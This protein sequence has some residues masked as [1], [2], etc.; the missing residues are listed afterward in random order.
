MV[1]SHAHRTSPVLRGKW[2]LENIIGVARRAP[3]PDDVPALSDERAPETSRGRGARSWSSTAP[4]RR[5]RAAIACSTRWD[6]RSRT[7]TPSARGARGMAGRWASPIDASGQLVDGTRRR[8][9][10]RAAAGAGPATRDV[11]ED[12]DREAA[13]LRGRPGPRAHRTCPWCARSSASRRPQDYR[14]SSLVLGIV[15]SAPFQMRM[16]QRGVT[17]TLLGARFSVRVQFWFVFAVR[18]GLRFAVRFARFGSVRF[19]VSVREQRTRRPDLELSS[20]I[21]HRTERRTE[22]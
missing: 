10:G 20:S 4:I 12:D 5:V 7:S 17:F 14:F 2:I 3:P 15:K 13:D 18:F 19:C 21:T 11:R 8:R 16:K 22:P 9:C 1:T 6:S